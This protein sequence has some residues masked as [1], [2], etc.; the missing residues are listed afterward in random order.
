MSWINVESNRPAGTLDFAFPGY[1][2]SVGGNVPIN[3]ATACITE[4]HAVIT[5][6]FLGVENFQSG[7]VRIQIA[8]MHG[9][10]MAY[11]GGVKTFAVVIY[12]HV[13]VDNF[14]KTI[15]IDISYTEVVV[16]LACVSPVFRMLGIMTIEDPALLQFAIAVIPGCQY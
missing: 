14:V 6:R 11:A 7:S 1:G 15:L 9:I 12:H 13:A 8:Q 5:H 10:G 16:A 2:L 3:F 4:I